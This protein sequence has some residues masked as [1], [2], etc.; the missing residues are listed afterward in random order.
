MLALMGS[1]GAG[2][3]TL[4]DVL[5]GIKTQGRTRGNVFLNGKISTKSDFNALA[6]YVQQFGTHNEKSTILGRLSTIPV[7]VGWK[8]FDFQRVAVNFASF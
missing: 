7:S 8:L 1:S 5:A 3:T 6:G 2:K 4:L